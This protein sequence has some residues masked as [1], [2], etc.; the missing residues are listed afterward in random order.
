[1]V[2]DMRETKVPAIMALNPNSV[3]VF[4]ILGAI[5]PIPPTWMPMEAK[6]AKPHSE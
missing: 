4:L 3:K 5:M 2:A 6:L 1:M